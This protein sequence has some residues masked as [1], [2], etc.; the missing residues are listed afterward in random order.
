V[1]SADLNELYNDAIGLAQH[2]LLSHGEF[3]P[4]GV[5]M[6]MSG[7]VAQVAGDLRT[8]HPTSAEM[9]AFLQASFEQ[10]A[11]QGSIRAAGVCIDMYV[12]P[13]GREQ[14]SDAICVRLAHISG[15]DAE[16]FV[17]YT[18]DNN[19]AFQLESAFAQA[20]GSFRLL[21]PNNSF[22]PKPLCGSA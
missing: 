3:I 13:P 17:P 9:V 1:A 21:S 7:S 20:G 12:L 19:G 11:H 6:D 15:E 4:F 16:V 14:K 2:M 10:Q 22:K 5:S 8:E 18:H